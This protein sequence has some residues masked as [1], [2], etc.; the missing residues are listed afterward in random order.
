MD[1]II[2]GP[3]SQQ[4]KILHDTNK[5]GRETPWAKHKMDA[6]LL[7]YAL[8]LSDPQAGKRVYDCAQNLWFTRN[9]EGLLKLKK[10]QFCRVRM[11]PICQWRRSLKMYGQLRTVIEALKKEREEEGKEPYKYILITLTVRNVPAESLPNELN[12]ICDA[13]HNLCHEKKYKTAI[14]GSMRSI[15][16]TYNKST[17]TYH[18]HIHALLC[19]LPSYF[20]SR[21]YISHQEWVDMWI[22]AAKINYYPQVDVRKAADEEGAIAEAAKYA[23]KPGDYLNASDVDEMAAT[24]ATLHYSCRKRRFATWAGNMRKTHQKLHLDDSENGDLI[25]ISDNIDEKKGNPVFRW[26]WY[27]GP[28]LYIGGQRDG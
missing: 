15:E 12:H 3:G 27:A 9:E 1:N 28:K 23:T 17:N 20:K 5:S 21:T 19:V 14:K 25:H 16:I 8:S 24:V 6:Q 10:S 7:S 4:A 26:D 2:A 22:K 13:W 11:C 18:P